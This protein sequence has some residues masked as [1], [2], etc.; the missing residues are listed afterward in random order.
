MKKRVKILTTIASLCLAVALMAFGVYAATQQTMTVGSTVSFTAQVAVTWGWEVEGGELGTTGVS[1][2]KQVGAGETSDLAF[3]PANETTNALPATVKF[4]NKENDQITY[5][6]TCHNDG[7]DAITV[8]VT[9]TPVV[10]TDNLKVDYKDL[11]WAGNH[12]VEA[13]GTLT[14]TVTFTMVSP[15]VAVNTS[16]DATFLAKH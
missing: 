11:A 6:F 14:L 10:E 7:N 12:T 5:T 3:N 13:N 15:T 4:T 16:F 1:G 2:T 9:H 8:T